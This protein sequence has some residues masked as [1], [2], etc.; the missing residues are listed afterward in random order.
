MTHPDPHPGKSA[1]EFLRELRLMIAANLRI[2]AD[3]VRYNNDPTEPG[4]FG[5]LMPRWEINYRDQWR[6]LPWHFEGPQYVDREL[7]RR[8]YG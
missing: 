6:E 1:D 4:Q 7:V 5:E 2:D 3:R 8:W